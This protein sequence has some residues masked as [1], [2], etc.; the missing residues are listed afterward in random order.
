M[1]S[2]HHQSHR[3]PYGEM[4]G[5]E[6]GLGLALERGLACTVLS[7]APLSGQRGVCWCHFPPAAGVS[8]PSA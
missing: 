4:L 6:S 1:V 5:A 8:L 3:L 7:I 2:W